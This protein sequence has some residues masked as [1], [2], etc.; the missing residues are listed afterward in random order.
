MTTTLVIRLSSLGDV[1]ILIPVLYSVAS[2]NPDDKFL[3]ITKKP[4]QPLFVNKPTNLEIFPVYTK[5]KHKGVVGLWRLLKEIAASITLSSEKGKRNIVKVADLHSVI[6]SCVID[7]YFWLK[8]GKVALIDK[9]RR[10]RRALVRK[11]NKQFHPL[12]TSL[13]RY[14]KVFEDLSYDANVDFTSLFSGKDP[15]NETWIGIAPFAKHPDKTYPLNQMEK[16]VHSLNER[17]NT[18]IYLFGG[19]EDRNV[20]ETWAE[21]YTH[22]KSV[23]GRLPFSDEF[24]LM[25]SLDVMVSMDSANMHLASLVNTPVVSVWGSTHPF[26][27]FYGFNQNPENIVQVDLD[28]RPCTIFGKRICYRSDCDYPCM[29]QISPE[30]IVAKVEAVL[31]RRSNLS[32]ALS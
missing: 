5:G 27:G 10:E 20:L 30:R 31:S 15:K 1:A 21:K 4:L 24:R 32:D 17:P 9:G 8:G 13:E 23:A 6:R 22:S 7:F 3:L 18:K 2:K 28:C 11:S 29:K 19:E 26:A 25:N 12:K 14:R 16:V